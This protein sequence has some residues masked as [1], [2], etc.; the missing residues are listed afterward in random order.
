MPAVPAS[1]PAR[2]ARPQRSGG[3]ADSRAREPAHPSRAARTASGVR[4]T[5]CAEPSLVCGQGPPVACLSACGLADYMK[6]CQPS[7]H[8]RLF[9]EGNCSQIHTK[10]ACQCPLCSLKEGV[11]NVEADTGSSTPTLCSICTCTEAQLFPAY[12]ALVR[13]AAE[14][15]QSSQG[16]AELPTLGHRCE[17]VLMWHFCLLPALQLCHVRIASVTS[18]TIAAKSLM[19]E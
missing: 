11:G 13:H 6:L 5:R 17:A 7:W 12:R 9:R 18:V 4:R 8:G 15:A 10:C 16:L 3:Q 14:A 19:D 1:H 2:R